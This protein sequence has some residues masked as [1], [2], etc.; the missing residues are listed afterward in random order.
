MAEVG[1]VL[2]AQRPSQDQRF[3]RKVRFLVAVRAGDLAVTQALL[4]EDPGLVQATSPRTSGARPTW[5]HTAHGDDLPDEALTFVGSID[6][7]PDK[8]TKR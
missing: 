6:Q 3:T 4:A 2:R 7:P 1:D 5:G 8:A